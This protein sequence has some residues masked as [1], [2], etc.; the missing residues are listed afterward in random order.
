VPLGEAAKGS[1]QC[2]EG[3]AVMPGYAADC[4]PGSSARHLCSPG[5]GV[6]ACMYGT[7]VY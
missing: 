5:A 7:V 1:G 3:S 6:G 4:T 2:N